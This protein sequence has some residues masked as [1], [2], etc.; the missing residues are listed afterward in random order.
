MPSVSL[1]NPGNQ[2][3]YDGASPS[4]SLSANNDNMSDTLSFSATGLPPGLSV[5]T[6]GEITGQITAT[7]DTSS[8]YAVSVTATGSPSGA[9]A[10]QSFNWYVTNP[11]SWSGSLANQ[12]NYDGN[13][14][15]LTLPSATDALY[16][17][18]YTETGLPS[19]PER[20][21]QQR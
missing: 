8:P 2:Y 3:N 1:V 10:S 18:A 19:G 9:T 16:D 4:V 7:A 20:P 21:V 13:T 17:L 15:S 6:S 5:D 11:V 12:S 14:V